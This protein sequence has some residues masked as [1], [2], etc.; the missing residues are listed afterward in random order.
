MAQVLGIM[1]TTVYKRTLCAAAAVEQYSRNVYASMYKTFVFVLTLIESWK[2]VGTAGTRVS[3]SE[4]SSKRR[5]IY[6]G[7]L[8]TC[9]TPKWGAETTT[10]LLL[11][12][13]QQRGWTFVEDLLVDMQMFTSLPT[14]ASVLSRMPVHCVAR[15]FVRSRMQ[16][17]LEAHVLCE[18]MWMVTATW[19]DEKRARLL[20]Q[21]STVGIE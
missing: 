2:T 14:M 17:G 18:Y 9:L 16:F 3:A 11:V 8:L 12:L 6:A 5:G 4:M 15:S 20:S 7:L 21:L 1:H 10:E 19:T 13:K